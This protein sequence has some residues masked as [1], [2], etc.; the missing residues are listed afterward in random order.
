MPEQHNAQY[1]IAWDDPQPGDAGS[2]GA[3]A[4]SLLKHWE[5]IDV[6]YNVADDGLNL[7]TKAV[8]AYIAHRGQSKEQPS[9]ASVARMAFELSCSE[10]TIQAALRT[11]EDR[12][13]I[14]CVHESKGGSYRAVSEYALTDQALMTQHPR[15]SYGGTPASNNDPRIFRTG[16]PATDAPVPPQMTH[17]TPA[18]DAGKQA[19]TALP[20]S[21]AGR[22]ARPSLGKDLSE[23]LWESLPDIFGCLDG[24]MPKSAQKAYDAIQEFA[25]DGKLI[26]DTPKTRYKAFQTR[27][28]RNKREPI[29]ERI[30]AAVSVLVKQKCAACGGVHVV[31][32]EDDDCWWY[33]GRYYPAGTPDKE[34]SED[35]NPLHD[36]MPGGYTECGAPW[37][38]GEKVPRFCGACV[39]RITT[40]RETREASAR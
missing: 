38:Q 18:T 24:D 39:Q 33:D 32:D 19:R 22:P 13:W 7:T 16:T 31:D 27:L 30:D 4:V 20:T 8:L 40:T 29:A 1:G 37:T 14:D 12:G 10:R 17:R 36:P 23:K 25:E 6:A 2:N 28:I 26:H 3:D 5:R 15:R 21:Q 35:V 34:G 9:R 11:L